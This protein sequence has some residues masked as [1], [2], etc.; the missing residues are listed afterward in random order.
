MKSQQLLSATVLCLCLTVGAEAAVVGPAGYTN[1]FSTQPAAADFSTSSSDIAGTSGDI[2]TA[3][4]LDAYVQNVAASAINAQ[5]T[6]ASP[7]DPPG[8]LWAAQWTSAGSAYLATHPTGN[9]ATVLMTTLVN[10]TGTNCNVLHLNYQLTVGLSATEEVPGQRLYYSFSAASN[11]WRTLPAVS[12][13]NASGLVSTN[14]ILSQTWTNG[15]T[16]YLLWVDDNS[17]SSTE[18]AYEIDN[19]FASAYYLELPLTI[20]LTGPA[21]GQ[22]FSSGEAITASVALTGSP[23]NVSYYVDGSL[24]VA[25]TTAPFTPVTLPAQALGPHTI[26]AT[27]LDTNNTF[28][29][30]LTNSFTVGAGLSGT[31]SS[32]TTLY[33][34]NS[35][36]TVSGNL[37]VPSWSH[38]RHRAGRDRATAEELRHHCERTVAGRRHHQPAHHLYPPAWRPELGTAHVR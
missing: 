12:G 28:V 25:R 21:S 26:Y 4:D 7:A 1:I 37:V 11:A 2:T 30:T 29:K 27:A 14:V 33:A 31:L 23:T 35:P 15:S 24:A 18:S 13:L 20:A 36:Y 6:D 22:L 38:A 5:V 3:T 16:V 19:F 9:R 8:K 32:D 10:N 34:S 17:S